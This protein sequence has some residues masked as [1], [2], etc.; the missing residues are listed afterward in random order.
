MSEHARSAF[1]PDRPTH[2]DFDP[3]TA[4]L[5]S[6]DARAAETGFDITEWMS[7]IVDPDTLAYVIEHRVGIDA[8]EAKVDLGS[9]LGEFCRA[10]WLEGFMAGALWE[11]RPKDDR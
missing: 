10:L 5:R 2:E 1:F 3:L 11:S 6:M 4:T 9:H 8:R 7:T